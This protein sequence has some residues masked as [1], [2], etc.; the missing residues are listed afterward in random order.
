MLVLADNPGLSSLQDHLLPLDNGLS[1]PGRR[2]VVL[3]E[4]G[5][6]C[7]QLSLIEHCPLISTPAEDY[8]K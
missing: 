6:S 2:G 7:L 4:T 8:F 3:W 5:E 1:Q